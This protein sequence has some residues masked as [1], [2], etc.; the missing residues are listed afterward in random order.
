MTDEV[1]SQH[2]DDE[3]L[4][5]MTFYNKSLNLVEINYHIY[6]KK[7]LIIIRCFEHWRSELAHTKLFIQIFIDHQALKIFMK[8]KQLTRRQARY[9]NILSDFNFKIIFR[10]DK[11]NIKADTLIRMLDSHSEDDDERIRQQHQIILISNRMQIL[12]N[13]MNEDG[14]TFD[15]I[16]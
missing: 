14:S 6:D 3:V 11:A 13:S 10:A 12:V 4:H 2:D 1:L 9:L 5:S 7:L 8:N 15:Q 16:V